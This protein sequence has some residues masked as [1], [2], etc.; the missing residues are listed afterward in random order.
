MVRVTDLQRLIII[1]PENHK[2]RI[3]LFWVSSHWGLFPTCSRKL[4]RSPH[5][6]VLF[7][8]NPPTTEQGF[9]KK[10]KKT[11]LFWV[12]TCRATSGTLLGDLWFLSSQVCCIWPSSQVS[13]PLLVLHGAADKVTDPTVSKFLYDTACSQ[14]KTMKIY[15]G[16]YHSIL[17]G[18]PDERISTVISD[19]VSW[20]DSHCAL[21]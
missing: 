7:L 11:S 14:D 5:C 17:E 9:R 15:D 21:V 6:L 20:L 19:I 16:G 3:F 8:C 2:A 12:M 13:S 4:L 18:E 1:S 10:K